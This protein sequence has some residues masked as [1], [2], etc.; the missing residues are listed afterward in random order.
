MADSGGS[1]GPSLEPSS[2]MQ[3]LLLHWQKWSRCEC[4]ILVIQGTLTPQTE[5]SAYSLAPGPQRRL[6]SIPSCGFPSYICFSRAPTS[7][8]QYHWVSEFAPPKYQ[9]FLSY[10]SGS[11]IVCLIECFEFTYNRLDVDSGLARKCGFEHLCRRN[12]GSS[13]D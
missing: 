4:L 12:A 13:Y 7:G 11:C 8:G 5:I 3:P 1:S 9:K 6:L 2:A 10:A